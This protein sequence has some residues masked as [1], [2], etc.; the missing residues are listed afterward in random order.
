M[1]VHTELFLDLPK[2]A[3]V[4]WT[5]LLAVTGSGEAFHDRAHQAASEEEVVDFLA[6]SADHQGSIVSPPSPRPTPI[7][8]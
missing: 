3:G 4:G 1:H 7:Y 2:A 6:I 8:G 5:P